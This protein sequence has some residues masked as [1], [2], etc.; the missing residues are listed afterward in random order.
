[1]VLRGAVP[2]ETTGNLLLD[3][4]LGAHVYWTEGRDCSQTIN[5]V[6]GELRAMGRRP[7]SSPWAA[8]TSSARRAMS[9]RWAN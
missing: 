8:R 7:T 9:W 1:V 6:M 3:K 2:A 5:G 4:L